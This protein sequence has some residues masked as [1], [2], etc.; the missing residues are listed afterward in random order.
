M[1]A[2]SIDKR[3]FPYKFGNRI[4]IKKKNLKDGF[5]KIRQ[6]T[7]NTD[8]KF[9]FHNRKFGTF[10]AVQVAIYIIFLCCPILWFFGFLPTIDVLV[11]WATEQILV[12]CIG[13]SSMATDFRCSSIY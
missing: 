12:H 3:L 1:K 13:G 8:S 5:E 11:S 7:F 4:F 10:L 2:S 9:I 6:Q